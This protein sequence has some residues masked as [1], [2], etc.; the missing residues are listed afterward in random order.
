MTSN[1]ISNHIEND[2]N[3]DLLL[4]FVDVKKE[5]NSILNFDS[6]NVDFIEN[7]LKDFDRS[8]LHSNYKHNPEL[9]KKIIESLKIIDEAFSK[10]KFVSLFLYIDINV[11]ILNHHF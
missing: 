10:F 1:T 9:L 2:F 4:K 5:E 3:N 8:F 11:D 7:D 6:V